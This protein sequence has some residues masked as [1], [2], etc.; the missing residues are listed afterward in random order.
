MAT[1]VCAYM[2]LSLVKIFSNCRKIFDILQFAP[3]DQPIVH[4]CDDFSESDDG[5]VWIL[6]DKGWK[7]EVAEWILVS[8][9]KSVLVTAPVFSGSTEFW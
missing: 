5:K 7:V 3:L 4:I 8:P 2:Y 9:T 6:V 1:A